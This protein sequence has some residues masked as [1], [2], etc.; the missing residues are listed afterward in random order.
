MTLLILVV[1]LM[2]KCVKLSDWSFSAMVMVSTS[3]FTSGLV[4]SSAMAAARRGGASHA[5]CCDVSRGDR[6]GTPAA[7]GGT[8]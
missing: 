4:S 6:P 1:F 3:P 7:A 8:H 2:R 5:A